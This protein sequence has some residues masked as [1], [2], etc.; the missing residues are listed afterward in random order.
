MVRGDRTCLS[1]LFGAVAVEDVGEVGGELLRT[2][3][4]SFET[5]GAPA[6][7]SR[8]SPKRAADSWPNHHRVPIRWEN[9]SFRL[10]E[11]HRVRMFRCG[12]RRAYA[13]SGGALRASVSA[14]AFS[15]SMLRANCALVI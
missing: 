11:R 4:A 13:R 14:D 12:A 9:V 3:D 5:K 6:S 8:A 15:S 2:M 7:V 1:E 10:L